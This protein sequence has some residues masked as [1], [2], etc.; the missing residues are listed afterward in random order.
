MFIEDLIDSLFKYKDKKKSLEKLATRFG[1]VVARVNQQVMIRDLVVRSDSDMPYGESASTSRHYT[2]KPELDRL[3]DHIQ[4]LF[5]LVNEDHLAHHYEQSDE[6]QLVLK[7]GKENSVTRLSLNE[8][9]LYT[10]KP[11]DANKFSGLV[12][13][14]EEMAKNLAPNVHVLL[15]SFAVL[16]KQGDVVNMCLFVEGGN[17]PK[18]HS[19]SKNTASMVDVDYQNPGQLFSQQVRGRSVTHHAD[20][21]GGKSG[22]SVNTGS[23][24][25]ITT[26]GG[27]SYTQSIDVCLDHIFGHSMNLLQR[28]ISGGASPDEIIPE[29]IEQCVT[30][31]WVE[32]QPHAMIA[33]NILHTD[34]VRSM[35]KDHH[36]VLGDRYISSQ[37]L[38]GI[39]PTDYNDMK[40]NETAVG[41]EIKKPPF[42]ADCIVEVLAERPVA[43]HLPKVHDAIKN[44]NDEV[45]NRMQKKAW[46]QTEEDKIVHDSYQSNHVIHRITELEQNLLAKCKPTF[47]Q[48]LF[49]TEE[50]RLKIDAQ[51]IIER[52][53]EL[54]KSN[55]Q[56]KGNDTLFIIKPWM[57]D[58]RFR[59]NCS[60]HLNPNNSF[61]KSLNNEI[62]S[63]IETKLQKDLACEFSQDDNPQS[64]ATKK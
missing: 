8:F 64:L 31:N 4:S 62:K 10:N 33:T 32:L 36:A 3:T 12:L 42:G 30:S 19:F 26:A 51:N 9:S 44:H 17:P 48:K 58:L 50:Y 54:I 52:S 46:A 7:E 21:I 57:K 23:V 14:I 16:T 38:N 1:S 5:S 22:D 13:K 41:Y 34:P 18:I 39:I 28:K 59:L 11:I 24:F 27:A 6:G 43:K 47:W 53:I 56:E 35:H 40:I 45:I 25:E 2:N 63:I 15:S 60:A 37:V 49:K 61:T 20:I 55:Y 29:Q